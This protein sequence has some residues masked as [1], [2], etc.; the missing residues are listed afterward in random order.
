MKEFIVTEKNVGRRLDVFLADVQEGHSR[1]YYQKLIEEGCILI[2]GEITS[3]KY[4]LL[5]GDIITLIHPKAK[6]TDII[7]ENIPLDIV[8][9]DDDVLVVDKVAGMVVHPAPGNYSGTLV[10]AIM[11][12]CGNRLSSINGEIRPGI[13]HRIDKDTSGLLMVAKNDM[14]HNSLASQFKDHSINREYKAI[15]YNN[16]QEEKGK[17]DKPIGRDRNNRKKRAVTIE[18]GKRAVTH[19]EMI[20]RFGKFS[21]IKCRLET[22][23]THQIRVHMAYINH[24][25]LGDVIYG[26]ANN[27]LGAKRQML[28]AHMIGFEHPRTGEYLEFK[29]DIPLDFKEILSK[30]KVAK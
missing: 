29:S 14:A 3:K 23:R 30:L 24:P 5:E 28:H 1:N 7:A 20:E 8:Y 22:G 10:N 19:W 2:N 21:F 12:H 13:V 25:L 15:V 4:K 26:P 17:V 16:F 9:E 11:Y 18:N 6:K 27:K